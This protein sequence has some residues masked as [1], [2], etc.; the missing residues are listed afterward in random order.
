[1]LIFDIPN[2]EKVAEYEVQLVDV[3]SEHLGMREQKHSYLVKMPS[4]ESAHICWDTDLI[5]DALLS[6]A[7]VG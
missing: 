1:M 2:Q 6:C 4:G 5:G 3:D 7:K